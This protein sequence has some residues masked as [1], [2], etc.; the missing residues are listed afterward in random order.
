M[1]A[2]QDIGLVQEATPVVTAE[3]LEIWIPNCADDLKPVVG[4]KFETIE[5]GYEFYKRY[6]SACGFNVRKSTKDTM[7]RSKVVKFQY[8]LCSC[9][10]Y[11]SHKKSKTSKKTLDT[12][13]GCK[14]KIIVKYCDKDGKY[15][16]STF[17]EGHSHN[18][19]SHSQLLFEK[20]GRSMNVMHK[21]MIVD[22]SRV[23]SPFL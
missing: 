7:P 9:E 11:K 13:C 12:R 21:K 3:G 20:G 10:G 19:Y 16:V 1:A 17:V 23:S 5:D 18:L 8:F 22:N 2:Q 15:E 14:A 6:A 4:M